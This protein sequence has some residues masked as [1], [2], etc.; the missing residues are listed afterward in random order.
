MREK[1]YQFRGHLERRAARHDR[2]KFDE[3]E[4]SVFAS[5]GQNLK[6]LTYGSDEYKAQLEKLGPALEHHYANNSHHPEHYKDG[7]RGMDL[8]D[9]V[10]MFCDWW[11]ATY[12]HSDGN[13]LRSI[14]INEERFSI[15]PELSDIF[16]NTVERL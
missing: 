15:P 8:M 5:V 1:L 2:S 11:A 16:R 13:I 10:E 9:L 12:R 14:A 6:N 3:P 4:F 7:I